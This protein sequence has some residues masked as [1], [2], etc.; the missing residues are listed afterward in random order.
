MV[1]HFISRPSLPFDIIPHSVQP[2]SLYIRP[3]SFPRSFYF[4]RPPSYVVLL[5]SRH[6]PI[7]LQPSFLDVLCDFSHF[8]CPP[9]S[10]ICFLVQLCNSAHPS[11]HYN[12]CDLRFIFLCLLQCQCI[13]PC[14]SAGRSYHCPIHLPLGPRIHF[15]VAQHYRH[16]LPVLPPA[17]HSG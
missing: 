12:L 8:R 14:T 11:K 6:M 3:S 10:F 9:Y 2:S 5:S 15:P 16:Y 7:P 13:F 17:L 4:H 1:V